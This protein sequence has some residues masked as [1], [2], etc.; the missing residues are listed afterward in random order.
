[1]PRIH[2]DLHERDSSECPD[3]PLPTYLRA[4]LQRADVAYL[5]PPVPIAGGFDTR[6]DALQ[7]VH[8]PSAFLGRLIVRIFQETNGG[9]RATA[10]GAL[11][12]ALADAGYLV[13]R[14]VDVCTDAAVPGGAFT[15][16]HYVAGQTLLNQW[17]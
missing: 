4:R 13:P 8:V 1:V 5:Q 7:L 3:E 16:M 17:C 10:E 2:V 15:L 9:Q 11:Q 14:V 6:I 12:N